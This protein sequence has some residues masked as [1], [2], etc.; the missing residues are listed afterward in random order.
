M[1]TSGFNV[2]WLSRTIAALSASSAP[3][4]F[5]FAIL[6]AS[7]RQEVLAQAL[8]FQVLAQLLT[9]LISGPVIDRVNRKWFLVLAQMLTGVAWATFAVVLMVGNMPET[10]F[11]VVGLVVG[12]LSGF[13]G[14]ATQSVVSRLVSK[15]ELKSRLADLRITLNAVSVLVPVAAGMLLGLLPASA[16]IFGLAAANLLSGLQLMR[17]PSLKVERPPVVSGRSAASE[18]LS[19]LAIPW[20]WYA[21][22]ATALMNLLWAGYYQLNGPV[23]F[24]GASTNPEL[25]WG[26]ACAALGGGMILGGFVFKRVT[27][28]NPR[29][30]P[31]LF[32][33]G[34]ALP[35][36]ALGLWPHPVLIAVTAFC[37][38]V[39]LEAFVVNFHAQVQLTFPDRLMGTAYSADAFVGMAL[40][41]LG[42]ALAASGTFERS[43]SQLVAGFSTVVIALAGWLVISRVREPGKVL[44]P[45][46]S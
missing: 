17:L 14:P 42:Y 46:D 28:K 10:V 13:N 41:P 38:G 6:Q 30:T 16:V 5:A 27:F 37:A 11:V 39:M 3:V 12:L 19:G 20:F 40:M 18:V 21:V 26:V 29:S 35:V 31:I 7:G 25:V 2:F 33:A 9:L 22:I 34:K 1:R 8:S 15:E 45:V 36:L 44:A 24:K 32:L 4:V 23:I 43:T